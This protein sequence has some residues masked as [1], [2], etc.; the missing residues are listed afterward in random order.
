MQGIGKTR[1]I[2]LATLLFIIIAMVAGVLRAAPGGANEAFAAT[3]ANPVS[4]FLSDLLAPFSGIGGAGSP[5]SSVATAAA[6]AP[7]YAPTDQYEADVMN[8]V[9]KASPAVVSVTISENVPVIENCP[10]YNPFDNVP[11]EFQQYFGGGG[12]GLSLPTSTPCTTGKTQLQQVG[13]GSG[14]II[15]PNGLILTN[16]HVVAATNAQYSVI[17][18]D[19]KTYKATVLARDPSQDLAVLKIDATNLP[20]VTLGNSDALQLGQTAIAIGNALGQFSN[21]VSVG[22]VSGLG[23]T[24]TASSPDTGAQETITGVIQTDAAINPGNS[25]GLLLDLQGDVIGI[26]TAIAS[27][28]QNIGFAIPINEAKSAINSVES[29]GQ[30]QAPY[31]G[32]MYEPVTPALAQQNDLPVSE[33]A[34]VTTGGQTAPVLA[35]SPAAKAGIEAGDIITAV[36]GAPVDAVHDL[37][38]LINEYGVGQTVT[39]TIDRKGQTLTLQA[40]LA[41][42]PAGQ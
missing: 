32:V 15:S 35:G 14:F 19:G 38:N 39:L 20:T 34:W 8:A 7:L 25:G 3:A 18:S 36:D 13:G 4:S 9:K 2:I 22:V 31:L 11:P 6:G 30:I 21:T 33:G 41:Q 29:T 5:S 27:N 28:A 37:A 1:K 24:V 42:R 10:A 17:T 40:T 12:I 26:D 23:R 16:K